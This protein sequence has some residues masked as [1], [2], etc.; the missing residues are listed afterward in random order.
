MLSGGSAGK[1]SFVGFSSNLI[2]S[3]ASV[4]LPSFRAAIG[5]WFS[6]ALSS[7]DIAPLCPTFG[8]VRAATARLVGLITI[9]PFA[10]SVFPV[11]EVVDAVV[12]LLA[13]E[14]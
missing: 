9:P 12:C 4:S 2:I 13:V 5:F 14:C 1:S 6:F 3:V 8:A 10:F 11:A 7:L